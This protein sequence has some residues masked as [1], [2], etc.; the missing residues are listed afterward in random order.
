M[1]ED[2]LV[3]TDAVDEHLL[4]ALMDPHHLHQVVLAAA[5]VDAEDLVQH[6]LEPH[7]DDGCGHVATQI[8]L[9]EAVD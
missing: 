8:S 5:A 2:V 1:H 4:E 6:A 9:D 3:V 7:D